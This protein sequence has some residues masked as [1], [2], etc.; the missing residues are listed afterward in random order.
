M[1]MKVSWSLLLKARTRQGGNHLYAG[2]FTPVHNSRMDF[3]AAVLGDFPSS[4]SLPNSKQ[5]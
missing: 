5:D 3:S 4:P 1:T 2:L